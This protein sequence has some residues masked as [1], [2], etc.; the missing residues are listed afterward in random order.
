MTVMSGTLACSKPKANSTHAHEPVFSLTIDGV[1]TSLMPIEECRKCDFVVPEGMSLIDGKTLG[2]A[3]GQT[4]CFDTTY[5]YKNVELIHLKGTR[6][7]P[8]IVAYSFPTAQTA[9]HQ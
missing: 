4:V 3:P 5:H 9:T 6:D 8:I 2:I 7:K 1:H